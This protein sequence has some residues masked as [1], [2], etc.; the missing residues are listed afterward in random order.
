[1]FTTQSQWKKPSTLPKPTKEP[2]K[3]VRIRADELL[4]A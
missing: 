4:T 2:P 3:T 1:L